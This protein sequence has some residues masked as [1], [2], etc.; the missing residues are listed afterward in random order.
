MGNLEASCH[1]HAC[2][3]PHFNLV[4]PVIIFSVEWHISVPLILHI[5]RGKRD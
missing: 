3:L 5:S 1:P 2:P 4:S